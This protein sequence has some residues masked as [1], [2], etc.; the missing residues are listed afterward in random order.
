MTHNDRMLSL[1]D[2][3]LTASPYDDEVDWADEPYNIVCPICESWAYDDNSNNY[4]M[5]SFHCEDCGHEWKQ[6]PTKPHTTKE[7]EKTIRELQ[8]EIFNL[9]CN[10]KYKKG[11]SIDEYF[12]YMPDGDFHYENEAG[13][14]HVYLCDEKDCPAQWHRIAY[15]EFIGRKDGKRYI[16]LY[17]VDSD[18]NHDFD[19][20]YDEREENPGDWQDI[21]RQLANQSD[22]FFLGWA[23]YWVDAAI[24]GKDPCED[25]LRN[26]DN[27]VDECIKSAK[28]DI[29]YF[30]M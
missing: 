20:S 10:R 30:K 26:P 19:N 5:V 3:W 27:W 8:K 12:E 16:E 2:Q 13:D 23:K 18:G 17:S 15:Y 21:S 7:Q 25:L 4:P 29:K 11:L 28:E 1:H 22:D 24:T 6:D 14:W 9:Q